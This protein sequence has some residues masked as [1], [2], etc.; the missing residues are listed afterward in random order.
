M[1][2]RIRAIPID[3]IHPTNTA[4][5]I[6][7]ME[8]D[9]IDVEA[10]QETPGGRDLVPVINQLIEWARFHTLP[11]I[12]TY[13]MHRAD[14]SDFG[15]ELEFDTLHCLEG[16]PGCEL[17]D[18]LDIQP[19]D[20]RILNKRRYDCFMGTELDLLLRSKRIENLICCGVTAHVC[21]MNTVYTARNLD[22]RV[23][24][25]KDAIAGISREYYQ[26]A[27]LCMSDVFAYV[28]TTDEVVSLWS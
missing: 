2:P 9:F 10:V 5:L 12:F 13:E 14:H 26:A 18:G 24:V 17:T 22:Y 20:Y 7:D 25:P 4:L 23:I 19:S 28:S 1:E 3:K 16:T 11:V 15:I 6:I 27:L 8:R 21:V